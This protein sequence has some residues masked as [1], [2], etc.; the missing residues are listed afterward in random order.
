ME[1]KYI[2]FI[3]PLQTNA[4]LEKYVPQTAQCLLAAALFFT[5]C[6]AHLVPIPDAARCGGHFSNTLMGFLGPGS[7]CFIG[8]CKALCMYARLSV[9]RNKANQDKQGTFKESESFAGNE[10]DIYQSL[11]SL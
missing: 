2:T 1:A 11:C 3:N 5:R 4:G 8:H 10:L 9:S 6:S 7:F